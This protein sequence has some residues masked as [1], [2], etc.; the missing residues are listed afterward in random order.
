MKLIWYSEIKWNY[1]Q[2]RKQNLLNFFP[3]SD[4]ILFFQPFSFVGGNHFFPK[5]EGNIYYITLPTYRKSQYQF[6]DKY[7]ANLTLRKIFYY[8]LRWYANIWINV[9]LKQSPDCICI[10]NIF[11]LPLIN[12]KTP[13]VWDFNDH[14]E[15]FEEQPNWALKSFDTFLRDKQYHIIASSKGLAEY[16]NAIYHRQTIIIPNGVDLKHFNNKI[17]RQENT[18]KHVIG[19]VGIISSWFFDFELLRKISEQFN[20]FKI[21]LYGPC[22]KNARKQLNKLIQLPNILY[23]GPKS[24]AELPKIMSTFT[25]GII[26]LYSKPEVWRLASGKFLQYLSVGIPVVSVWMKQ[27]SKMKSNVFLSKSHA[28]FITGLEQATEYKFIPMDDE[29]REYDWKYLSNR[30]RNELEAAIGSFN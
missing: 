22:E 11:Y 7:F 27:F 1:L 12:S 24:Y 15:Q 2:T 14:P 4:T 19:Y 30:F 23:E 9:I 20:S 16:I 3:S 18:E 21:C 13:I 29:L 5:K 25:V 17:Q 28:E 26:P 8:F 6:I 10:S